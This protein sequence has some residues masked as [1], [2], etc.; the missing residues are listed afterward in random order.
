LLSRA[1]LLRFVRLKNRG[2]VARVQLL[3]CNI[4]ERPLRFKLKSE[5]DAEIAALPSGK[6]CVSSRGSARLVLTWRR[7]KQFT[8]WERAPQPK[9]L[10]ITQ[11]MDGANPEENKLTATRFIARI[12]GVEECDANKPP[13]EQLMLDA[14]ENTKRAST[15]Y[16]RSEEMN[17]TS[18]REHLNRMRRMNNSALDEFIDWLCD[19]PRSVL[20]F[21]TVLAFAVYL[22]GMADSG[23]RGRHYNY[24]YDMQMR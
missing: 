13:V 7:P 16:D 4:S 22:L 11:F 23:S 20:A 12:F 17:V 6:G 15:Q 5:G 14:G 9:L 21:L 18:A 10:L 19:Q 8:S 3:L 1:T 24:N 2:D